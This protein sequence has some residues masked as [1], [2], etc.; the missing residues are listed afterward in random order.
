MEDQTII[1]LYWARDEQAIRETEQKY[2]AYCR[3]IAHGILRS[4][5]DAEECVNDTWLRAWNVIPPQ[6]P[7]VLRAF[8]GKITRNLSLKV[9]ERTRA[10]KRGGGQ[11]PLV[12]EELEDVYHERPDRDGPEII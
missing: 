3:S 12:L 9:W 8:L 7:F 4:H 11:L 2:G 1:E 6:R 10:Q 5:Q